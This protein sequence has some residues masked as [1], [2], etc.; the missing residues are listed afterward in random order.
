MFYENRP[1]VV[2]TLVYV[3]KLIFG[4]DY[5]EFTVVLLFFINL[6][7]SFT[8]YLQLIPCFGHYQPFGLAI[9]NNSIDQLQ[10]QRSR[11]KE[12][13]KQ[14]QSHQPQCL[15]QMFLNNGQETDRGRCLGRLPPELCSLSQHR[16]NME[17]NQV[18]SVSDSF[19][20]MQV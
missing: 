11:V 12:R 14:R 9:H 19:C 15:L 7:R 6:K 10:S 8:L 5:D 1:T 13:E 4:E 17:K 16:I 2:T 18:I 3:H 20:R